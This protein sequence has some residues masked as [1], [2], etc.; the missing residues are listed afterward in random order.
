M[1]LNFR[2]FVTAVA[3]CAASLVLLA[4][5][6]SLSEEGRP[7]E[8]TI[9]SHIRTLSASGSTALEPLLDRWSSDYA[10]SHPVQVNYRSIGSGAGIDNLRHGYGAFAVSDAPLGGDQLQGL[11]P[12]VQIP[13]SIEP[14]SIVYNLP[15]LKAPLRLSGRTLAG[16]FASEII[17]WQDPSIAQ[18]NPGAALPHAAIILVHRADGSGTT[19]ILTNYLAK[20]NPAWATRFGQGLTAK[21]PAGIGVSGSNAV[22]KAIMDTPGAIGY[23]DLTFARTSGVST[24]SIQNRAGEFMAPTPASANLAVSAF[25]GQLAIDLRTPVVDPP[26]ST[27]GAYP[28]A[29]MTFFL[30]PKDSKS[31]DGEQQALKDYVTYTLTSGQGAAEQLSYA[32]LPQPII[33]QGLALLAQLSEN[34]K[35]VK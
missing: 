12:I 19:S 17:S 20:V 21:W 4:T 27:K 30:I 5:G 24:A 14:V 23:L 32:K 6:C 1:K 33:V 3:A 31:T 18:E 16:I 11:P 8:T 25:M 28:I 34:G 2:V 9:V 29:G 13:V 22:L 15:G 35:L 26:A 7:K 10:G